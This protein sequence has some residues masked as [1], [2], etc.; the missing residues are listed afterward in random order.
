MLTE[1]KAQEFADHWI[2]S[3]NSHDLESIVSHYSDD[4][5]YFSAFLAKLSGNASGTLRG[6]P[7][8]KEYLAKGLAAY[9]NLHFT[10]VNVFCGVRSVV[11]QYQSVNN[12]DAAE[13]FE[14]NDDGLVDRVQCHYGKTI[15]DAR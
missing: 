15:G 5:E 13:V 12:L 10:L 14:F 1:K 3:W 4:V 8:V 9:P 7:A 11:L 6:K 2:R